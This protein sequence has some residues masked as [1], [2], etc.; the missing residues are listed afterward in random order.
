M[1]RSSTRHSAAG[2]AHNPET[3][4][5]GSRPMFDKYGKR[6][7]GIRQP[8]K[9][10]AG[11]FIGE[12][13]ILATELFEEVKPMGEIVHW[14]N[15]AARRRW[16]GDF[17]AAFADPEKKG[18]NDLVIVPVYRGCA[19]RYANEQRADIRREERKRQRATLMAAFKAKMKELT[20]GKTLDQG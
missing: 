6:V 12:N 13:P 4:V 9:T 16:D 15:E 19:M 1:S 11:K 17:K 8:L 10:A 3:Y 14:R 18:K 20:E 2:S 7:V 5:L